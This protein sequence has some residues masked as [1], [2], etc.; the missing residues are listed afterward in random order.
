MVETQKP[1]IK[2][3]LYTLSF[4]RDELLER[5]ETLRRSENI[6]LYLKVEKGK[7]EATELQQLM[8]LIGA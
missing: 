7:E 5:I 6:S 2:E 4:T 8:Q 1:E 3:K